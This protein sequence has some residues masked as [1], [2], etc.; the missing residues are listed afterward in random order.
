[1]QFV[2]ERQLLGIK[3]RD[4]ARQHKEYHESCQSF[5]YKVGQIIDKMIQNEAAENLGKRNFDFP[6]LLLGTTLIIR[7][8]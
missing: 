6:L 8:I 7:R 2:K 1:M 4:I 5:R 3:T